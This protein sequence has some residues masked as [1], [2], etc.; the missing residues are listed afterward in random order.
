MA[1]DNHG[2]T[3]SGPIWNFTTGTNYPPNIP[4]NPHPGNGE[5]NVPI[6][7]DLSWTGGDPNPG[8]TVTYD[9]YF[10]T[11]SPPTKVSVNQSGTTYDP[12]TLSYNTSYYWQIVAWDDK[13]ASASGSIWEFTTGEEFNQPPNTPSIRGSDSIIPGVAFVRPNKE[14]EFTI[15]TSDSDGDDVHYWVDWGDN[16]NSGWLGPYPTSVEI[17]ANHTWSQPIS[18]KFVKVKAK[19][20]YGAESGWGYLII[21]VN[22][23]MQSYNQ[24]MVK[25][26]SQ[27]S[28]STAMSGQSIASCSI[29]S[30]MSSHKR[31]NVLL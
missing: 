30:R 11:T 24:V 14:Y 10:G 31:V 20:I 29:S 5:T 7:I 15:V 9:V 4:S 26:G 1:W 13:G 18:L 8:D 22:C 28:S 17:T 3:S 6:E 25:Q 16:S 23:N 21:I 2:A 19:D 12:G 27:S